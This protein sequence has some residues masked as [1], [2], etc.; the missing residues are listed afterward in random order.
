MKG[1]IVFFF[2]F[3]IGL[4]FLFRF[5]HSKGTKSNFEISKHF[6]TSETVID[7]GKKRLTDIYSDIVLEPYGCFSNLKGKFFL[8]KV[9][10]YSK[11]KDDFDSGIIISDTQQEKDMR[12]L[13]E[14][15]R[16]NGFDIYA[17]K[18][19]NKYNDSPDK[20][21]YTSIKEIAALGKL[22]GYNYLS[23]YKTGTLEKGSIYLTYSPPMDVSVTEM[24]GIDYTP[25]QY[26]NSLTKSDLPNYALT[27]K[28]N[29]YTDDQ[30]KEPGKELGCGYPCLPFGE[31][32]TFKDPQGNIRQ[33]MCG[34]VSYPDIKT[35]PR[36]AVYKIV[37]R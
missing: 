19:Y 9:N 16:K 28:L 12:N 8:K 17:N 1:Y 3:A 4:I 7:R 34:S 25:E 22:A 37:E 29:N 5:I 26:T 14:R 20:Y 6:E 32:L 33:F 11:V 10:P 31:P 24:Y 21:K 30:R 2:I 23:I 35:P 36:Y 13:I 27:P 18:I 15:V